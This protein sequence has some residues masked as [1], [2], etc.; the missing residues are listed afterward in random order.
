MDNKT[1]SI[2]EN[3]VLIEKLSKYQTAT[4]H[5]AYNKRGALPSK[6]K[7]LDDS[8]SLTGTA[9]TVEL[10]PGDNLVLHHAIYK[11]SKGNVLVVDAKGYTEAG[12]WGEVMSRAAME[13]GISGLVVYG[14]VRDKREIIKLGFPVFS[15]GVCVK[16]TTKF[17]PGFINKPISICDVV[18]E[19]GDLIRGNSDGVVAIKSRDVSNVILNAEKILEKEKSVLKKLK[20]GK[21]TLEIYNFKSIDN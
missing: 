14:C 19:P 13:V 11:A 10:R 16:G 21:S 1:N 3:Q 4:L 6:I 18:I 15:V 2:H 9:V 12:V 7:P 20:E 8:F 5:E 17:A